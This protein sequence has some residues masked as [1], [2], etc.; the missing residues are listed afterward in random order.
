MPASKISPWSLTRGPCLVPLLV[1]PLCSA[2]P[3]PPRCH[4][5]SHTGL[6]SRCLPHPSQGR[7]PGPC[8]D[9]AEGKAH[10]LLAGRPSSQ[11]RVLRAALPSPASWWLCYPEGAALPWAS[12]PRTLPAAASQV[13]YGWVGVC[14][15]VVTGALSPLKKKNNKSIQGARRS[16]G[17]VNQ[18]KR[19][20]RW[21]ECF[22]LSAFL[23]TFLLGQTGAVWASYCVCSGGRL[24]GLGCLGL[25]LRPR[26]KLHRCSG[27]TKLEITPVG[28]QV[29]DIAP[30]SS[31][32]DSSYTPLG[33]VAVTSRYLGWVWPFLNLLWGYSDFLDRCSCC[34]A[35]LSR[36]PMGFGRDHRVS[37]HGAGH[38]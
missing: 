18:V 4:P 22:L 10:C 13:C 11:A 34:T 12:C 8:C 25:V 1:S 17:I 21:S 6:S 2:W 35:H 29:S 20:K 3:G 9:F 16:I 27:A 14:R 36:T 32:A 37:W 23:I 24:L 26:E 7:L 19:F 15:E 30:I 31:F 28:L 38:L 33:L 5:V